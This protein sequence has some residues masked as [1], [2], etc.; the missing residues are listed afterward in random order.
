MRLSWYTRTRA[1]QAFANATR[2]WESRESVLL[3]LSDG[4]GSYGLGEATPLPGYSPDSVSDVEHLLRSLDTTRCI[5]NQAE[6]LD[7]VLEHL[8]AVAPEAPP[9]A[10]FALQSAALDLWCKRRNT[11]LEGELRRCAE[12]SMPMTTSA[13]VSILRVAPLLDV[14]SPHFHTIAR[15]HLND[16]YATYKAKIGI[17][18]ER[19]IDALSW[20]HQEALARGLN[21]RLRL[22]ANQSLPAQ[23]LNATLGAFAHLP[24]E[25]VEEPCPLETLSPSNPL[26]L[27]LA[28]DES[29]QRGRGALTPWLASGRLA[30]FVCKPMVMGDLRTVFEWTHHARRVDCRFVLS[31]LFD[32]PVA[33]RVYQTLALALAPE[34]CH[35][36]AQHPGLGL[37]SDWVNPS[38]PAGIGLQLT[39]PALATLNL[40]GA[41]R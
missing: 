20:L 32:G 24:V 6:N 38:T 30:A 1:V 19:E 37:W 39:E 21:L 9:S 2:S 7:A 4:D 8:D 13:S 14:H 5:V 3:T 26:P 12:G 22:D 33:F 40:P 18:L 36:L 16:G 10:R 34:T 28:L 35:G 41:N 23:G 11:P 15:D 25:Y 17:A 29:L 31:H 27:P